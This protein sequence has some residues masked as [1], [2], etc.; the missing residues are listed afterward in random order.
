MSIKVKKIVVF[1]DLGDSHA[2]ESFEYA[3]EIDYPYLDGKQREL[4]QVEGVK[5]L[6]IDLIKIPLFNGSGTGK[7]ISDVG[8]KGLLLLTLRP[9]YWISEL[10][11]DPD[12][13]VADVL[14]GEHGLIYA[15]PN[16]T[17]RNTIALTIRIAEDVEGVFRKISGSPEDLNWRQYFVR[18]ALKKAGTAPVE[19]PKR[20]FPE[21]MTAK[22]VADYLNVAEK[23]IR[24]WTHQ[25]KIPFINLGTSVRYP[26]KKIDQALAKSEIGRVARRKKS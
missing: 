23:T 14:Y 8:P 1:R 15:F 4:I 11:V 25:N 10:M 26:K 6:G 24:N 2:I 9:E 17:R 13:I 5:P 7:I 16:S 18:R 22:D 21:N 19:E 20:D 3:K 12:D